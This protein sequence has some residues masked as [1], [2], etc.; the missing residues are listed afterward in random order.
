MALGGSGWPW[1]PHP[2]PAG[3]AGF[4]PRWEETLRF[5]VRVPELALVRFVVEDYD[6]TSCNDFVGQFTLPLP[7]MRQ[8]G[9]QGHPAAL[10][11]RGQP[12]AT[13]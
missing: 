6:S 9:C 10:R 3:A 11:G 5:Q 8:G 12:R 1:W 13:R 7:S 4:N 2:A